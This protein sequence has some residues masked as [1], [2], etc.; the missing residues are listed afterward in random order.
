MV[1]VM[2]YT[3]LPAINNAKTF[4]KKSAA[5]QLLI[6]QSLQIIECLGVP[7]EDLSQRQREKTAMALLAV[8]GVT[9]SKG[10]KKIKDSNDTY[11]STTREIIAFH[12]ANL[13]ENISS[14][15]Y[16]DIRRQD[17]KRLLVSEIVIQSKPAAN[18]S[19]PTRGYRINAEY[20]RIIR[21][22]GQP[23]WFAQVDTFNQSHKT[24]Q[25]R[26]RPKRILQKLTV[27][28]PSGQSIQLKD[29]EH[30]AI[31]KQIIEEFLPRY[32]NEAI[33]LYCGDSD[34]KYGI[35]Y[36]KAQL[37]KLGFNDL[38]QSKLPDVVAYSP[39]KDWIYLIEAYHTSNPITAERKYEL[40][41]MMGAGAGKCVFVTAFENIQSYRTCPEDL[42]WETEVW[43]ATDPD[44]MIHRNGS[45]FMGPY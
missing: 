29:G 10:W 31:Q 19:N 34:N 4:N 44:H 27:K 1:E 25:E 35:V 32:G 37:E 28:T 15:S 12:N 14:G 11:S 20:S 39:V 36:E 7:I 22:Y 17:L 40:E 8:G 33:L 2:D 41:Q 42:A 24:Y 45:R 38:K 30:N 21:N 3:D 26:V 13:E 23:D 5:V 18:T 16:D 9:S 43:I 6:R